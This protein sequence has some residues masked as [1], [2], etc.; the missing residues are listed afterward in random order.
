M[1]IRVIAVLALVMSVALPL[2]SASAT[3][4]YTGNCHITEIY[5]SYDPWLTIV[6]L[7]CT[8]LTNGCASGN[9]GLYAITNPTTE[10]AASDDYRNK[11]P[12]LMAAYLG[13]RQVFLTLDGCSPGS[14]YPLVREIYI[15]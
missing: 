9:S 11:M 12:L 14:N 2:R 7:D 5:N 10:Y 15:K 8:A 3:I 6:T 4:S 1:R 13:N